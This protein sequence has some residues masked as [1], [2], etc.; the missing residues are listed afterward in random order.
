MGKLNEIY[1]LLHKAYGKQGWWPIIN[2][3]TLLCE[4]HTGTPKNEQERFEIVIGAVLAQNTNWYPNVVRAI[5]QLKLGRVLTKKEQE[6]LREAEINPNKISGTKQIITKGNILTQNTSWANVEKAIFNLNKTKL[7]NPKKMAAAKEFEIAACVRPAGYYNQKAKRL[8][9][10]AKYFLDNPK[11]LNKEIKELR[12][13]LL[14]LNGIG[15]ETAD[16][17]ILY[18]AEKPSFVIDTYTKRI[19]S[20]LLAKDLGDYNNWKEFFESNLNHDVKLFNEY[21]A[22]IVEHAKQS[23]NKTPKCNNCILKS[24]CLYQNKSFLEKKNP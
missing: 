6:E 10:I 19:L 18:A 8:K 15:P 17:I 16:S 7:L 24:G 12:Q 13:E 22:L 23:C 21:H 1:K 5:Q 11:L 9:F 4:Y 20:R 14:S 3:K 2:D